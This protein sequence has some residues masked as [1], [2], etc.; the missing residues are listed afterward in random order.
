MSLVSWI[1]SRIVSS[2]TIAV[3]VAVARFGVAPVVLA[4]AALAALLLSWRLRSGRRNTG[5]RRRGQLRRADHEHEQDVA[6]L[7]DDDPDGDDL[8]HRQQ[9]QQNNNHRRRRRPRGT[10]FDPTMPNA[11]ANGIS[12]YGS[13]NHT[14][15]PIANSST[16]NINNSVDNNFLT[17]PGSAS[18][19]SSARMMLSSRKPQW[20]SRVRR[21]TIGAVCSA[22]QPCNL[23]AL[24]DV[25]ATVDVHAGNNSGVDPSSAGVGT[26]T[27]SPDAEKQSHTQA[28]CNTLA[29]TDAPS[30]L[31]Q[32]DASS[33]A[34]PSS[35]KDQ[36]QQQQ[37]TSTD[38]SNY[39]KIVTVLPDTVHALRQFAA[40]FDVYLVIRVDSDAMEVAV[41]KAL[42]SAGVFAAGA[43]DR[44]KL[45]FCE[46]DTGRVSVA[47]QLES[48]LHV[49]ESYDVIVGLQRFVQCMGFISPDAPA[50]PRDL[51]GRNVHLHQ[52]LSGFFS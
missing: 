44:R 14:S 28:T 4:S 33:S 42:V 12:Q 37:Q 46:T 52:S 50:F 32:T 8:S 26:S 5:R 49:D 43:M 21:V 45:I 1:S 29:S 19:S 17:Q 38:P 16:N 7:E 39:T 15:M 10:D 27:T 23:F 34:P 36:Q 31:A 3:R 22:A 9:H 13:N 24:D 51:L 6:H 47:R 35:P 18:A 2:L 25:P 40:L 11:S 41:T 20:L 30:A 48:Q